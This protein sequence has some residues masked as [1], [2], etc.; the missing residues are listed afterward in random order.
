MVGN[1]VKIQPSKKRGRDESEKKESP[2]R[3]VP[4]CK[5]NGLQT[6]EFNCLRTG[7]LKKTF[8]KH[9]LEKAEK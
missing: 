2:R 1:G 3:M 5:R 6:A 4:R 8:L 9:E 7:V